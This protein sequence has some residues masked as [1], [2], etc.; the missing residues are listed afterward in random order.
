MFV[1]PG[2]NPEIPGTLLKVRVP[3]THGLLPDA[4]Q[5]VPENAFWLQRLA[6]G[7]VVIPPKIIARKDA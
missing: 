7:D 4:G 3:R 1:K 5:E 6:H 2:P